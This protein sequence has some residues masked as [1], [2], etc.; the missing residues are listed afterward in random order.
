MGERPIRAMHGYHPDAP[1]S[2]ASLL[3]NY[4]TVPD[5]ITAI[6]HVYELMATQAEQAAKLNHP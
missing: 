3:T 2:Y 4:T 5:H 1:H 6:P